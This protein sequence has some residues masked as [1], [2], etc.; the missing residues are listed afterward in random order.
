MSDVLSAAAEPARHRLL[1]RLY[2][3]EGAIVDLKRRARQRARRGQPPLWH[4]RR[5]DELRAQA[6]GLRLALVSPAADA[7]DASAHPGRRP[8]PGS[9]AAA[10]FF[11]G[12]TAR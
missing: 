3:T 9:S 7:S 2:E 5:V 1:Q 12:E 4:A 10:G 8:P 6:R 11:S